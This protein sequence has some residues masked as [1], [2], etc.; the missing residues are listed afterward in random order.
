MIL[1]THSLL[2]M[3]PGVRVVVPRVHCL[4]CCWLAMSW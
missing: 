3:A 2:L 4:H 1:P